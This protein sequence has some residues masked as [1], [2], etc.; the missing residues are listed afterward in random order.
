MPVDYS[1]YKLCKDLLK[2][3]RYV[4]NLQ[5]R[6]ELYIPKKDESYTTAYRRF[7]QKIIALRTY[8]VPIDD[9]ADLFKI[10]KKIMQLMHADS[11]SNS[12]TWYLEFCEGPIKPDSC[13]LLTNYDLETPISAANVQTQL[14]FARSERELFA[15]EEMGE[16]IHRVIA[17][18]RDQV[19]KMK[20]RV[21]T[22]YKVLVNALDWANQVF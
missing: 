14:D 11:L 1:F 2:P 21:D 6:L 8:S 10:E 16:D 19:S 20:E 13:L 9:I 5:F 3:K 12:P 4:Q 15:G 22:E 7:L 17:I 18:Y